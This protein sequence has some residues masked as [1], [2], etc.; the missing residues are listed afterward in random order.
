MK[1]LFITV[2]TEEDNSWDTSSNCLKCSNWKNIFL[3]QTI[4]EKYHFKPIYLLSYSMLLNNEFSN[5]LTNLQNNSKCFLGIHLHPWSTP[6]FIPSVDDNIKNRSIVSDYTYAQL[7]EKISNLCHLFRKRFGTNPTICRAGRWCTSNDYFDVL[8]NNGCCI[9]CSFTPGLNLTSTLGAKTNGN[10]YAKYKQR[11]YFL[12]SGITEIPMT[13]MKRKCLYG[14]TFK[15]RFKNFLMGKNFWLRPALC[16]YN[17]LVYITNVMED[18]EYLMF[19][20][21]STELFA[22]LNPYI[23]TKYELTLFLK[24]I[25][26]Y[27]GFLRN[28][29]YQT[30]GVE[31]FLIGQYGN[32]NKKN[33]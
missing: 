16:D 33:I 19:M 13:T 6:P 28:K 32:K 22:G 29:G 9:D 8:K 21:H 7:N 20:I 31:A 12:D 23:K 15:S 3:F 26:K 14:K 24:N 5:Y 1:T 27:F 25:K 18:K 11:I 17:E 4:C 2:D 10:N 30:I